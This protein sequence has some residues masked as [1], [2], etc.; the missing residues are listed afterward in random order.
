[1]TAARAVI[2]LFLL[3]ALAAC[4]SPEARRS[5]A[6]GPG[7]DVGNRGR[8]VLMHEG[9]R[10]FYKTPRIIPTPFVG[11]APADQADRLSRK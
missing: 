6:G 9:S 3:A 4:A 10:P 2:L 7:A 8:V 11:L 1:M 5:R